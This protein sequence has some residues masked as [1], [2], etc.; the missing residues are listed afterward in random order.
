MSQAICA[1]MAV[2]MIPEKTGDVKEKTKDWRC[3]GGV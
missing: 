2:K 1:A 3:L